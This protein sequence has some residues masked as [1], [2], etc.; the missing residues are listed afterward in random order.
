MYPLESDSPLGPLL[1]EHISELV[2]GL[3]LFAL[4]W[5]IMAKKVVP[6][7]E[8]TYQ[9]RDDAIRGGIERAE[10]AQSEAETALAQYNA[11]LAQ[12]EQEASQ[13]RDQARA[14]SA[15]AQAEARRRA[16]A[17]ADRILAG[18]RTQLEA[19]RTHAMTELRGQIGG[20]ATDLAGKILGEVLT[21]DERARRTVDRFIADLETTS[22]KA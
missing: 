9:Q 17:E 13:I 14:S 16:E 2:V 18:A 22:P 12:A 6:T 5:F 8:R 1:P 19:D 3:I 7:F 15:Q 21:E 20:L 4:I 11:Q 10:R